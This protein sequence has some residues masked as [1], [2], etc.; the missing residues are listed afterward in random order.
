MKI[1]LNHQEINIP[2]SFLW[3]INYM[4]EWYKENK[5]GEL[6]LI[7]K[8]GGVCGMHEKTEKYHSPPKNT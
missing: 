3:V 1:T 4:A 2:D 5:D 8:S 6:R 7:F